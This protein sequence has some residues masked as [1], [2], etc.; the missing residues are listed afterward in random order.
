MSTWNAESLSLLATGYWHSQALLA[1]VETGLFDTLPASADSAAARASTHPRTTLELLEALT[2][3]GLLT[4]SENTFDLHPSARPYLT[5]SSTT[6]LLPALRFNSQMY[7]LWAHLPN[8]LR[9]GQPSAPP[10]AHLGSD[11]VRTR[12]F[13]L[14]MHSRALALMP[15][16]LPHLDL[17]GAHTLL[18]VGSGPGTLSRLLC[19]KYPQLH[20]TCMDLPAVTAAAAEL[21]ATH[22]TAPRITHLPANYLTDPLPPGPFNAVIYCGALHQ[23]SP[24]QAQPLI[25][26][27]AAAL[28]PTGTLHLIDFFR[29][30]EGTQP[31]PALFALNM[32]L[33]SP[34]SHTH[35]ISEATSYLTHAQLPHLTITPTPLYTLLS[36]RR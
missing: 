34:T 1:A 18:D 29:D 13:V 12:H 16:L 20:A 8:T 19:A 27:L 14:G 11:P 4:R 21:T 10:T 17:S 32:S 22:P 2:A 23:H 36:A 6:S 3:L 5:S 25:H 35:S 9:T 28:S 26:R 30:A 24:A 33:L 15:T 7:Q 31:F